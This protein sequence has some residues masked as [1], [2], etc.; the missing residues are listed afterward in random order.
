MPVLRAMGEPTWWRCGRATPDGHVAPEDL[1]PYER[2]LGP[3]P[4]KPVVAESER[5]FRRWVN[6]HDPDPIVYQGNINEG[7]ARSPRR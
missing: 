7:V 3:R 4:P 5:L 2:P 1:D 6:G